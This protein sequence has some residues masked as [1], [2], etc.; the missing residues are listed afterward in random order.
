MSHTHHAHTHQP[1]HSFYRKEADSR[2]TKLLRSVLSLPDSPHHG[3]SHSRD[4]ESGTRVLAKD[5]HEEWKYGTIRRVRDED[6]FDIDFDTGKL[7]KR[8]SRRHIKFMDSDEEQRESVPSGDFPVEL[9]D[10]ESAA[11]EAMELQ[12]VSISGIRYGAALV[13]KDGKKIY[14]AHAVETKDG[15]IKCSAEQTVLLKALSDE[16]KSFKAMLICSDQTV[17]LPMPNHDARETMSQFGSF[18]VYVMNAQRKYQVFRT[19]DLA[20]RKDLAIVKTKSEGHN[21]RS[22]SVDD[23]S[24]WLRHEVKLSQHVQK[25]QES[26]VDGLMLLKISE[27]DMKELLGVGNNLHRRK[28]LDAIQVLREK[29]LLEYGLENGQIEVS[30]ILFFLMLER[31]HLSLSLFFFPP[32][33][34]TPHVQ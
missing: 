10:L 6:S 21:V 18:E 7:E 14:R 8:V 26:D 1:N 23:V 3:R 25:F 15:K 20:I 19:G 29:D 33:R 24:N 4:L 13:T 2:S 11:F 27:D 12:D 32:T 5:R 9:S 28:L 17:G 30:C 31:K 34:L 22:W 16:S